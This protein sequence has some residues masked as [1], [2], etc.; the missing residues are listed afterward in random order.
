MFRC[1]SENRQQ[2]SHY[3]GECLSHLC[4]EGDL[5]KNLQS[6]QEHLDAFKDFDESVVAF[7][8]VL[9]CL[10][11]L[12]IVKFRVQVID[13]TTQIRTPRSTPIAERDA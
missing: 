6:I 9:D 12:D 7:I 1:E 13:K 11:C 8:A 4:C 10:E 2:F 3:L 5:Y